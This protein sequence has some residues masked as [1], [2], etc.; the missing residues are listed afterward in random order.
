MIMIKI[1]IWAGK[2]KKNKDFHAKNR[3]VHGILK[4]IESEYE[5][6]KDSKE[7]EMISD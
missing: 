1:G 6:L 3:E 7:S 2:N 4:R 5:G